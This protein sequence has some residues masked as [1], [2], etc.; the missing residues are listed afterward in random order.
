MDGFNAEY[1]VY[2]KTALATVIPQL[3]L[4]P[5]PAAGRLPAGPSGL[6]VALDKGSGAAFYLLPPRLAQGFPSSASA[7]SCV[8]NTNRE[9]SNFQCHLDP[10]KCP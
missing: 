1:S 9:A 8:R 3:V 10:L 4:C 5:A 7:L 6:E 2:Q